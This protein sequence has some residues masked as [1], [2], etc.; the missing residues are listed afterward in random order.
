MPSNGY[1][2]ASYPCLAKQ[3]RNIFR[4]P[5][6]FFL[7]NAYATSNEF[8]ELTERL[9]SRFYLPDF[10]KSASHRWLELQTY[11]LEDLNPTLDYSSMVHSVEVRVPFLDHRIVEAA[12]SLDANTH[13]TADYGRKSPLKAMLDQH[14]I[15]PYIWARPK[16][17]FSLNSGVLSNLHEKKLAA[18]CEL[19]TEG[20][21]AI[22]ARVGEI[23][24][25][26]AYLGSAALAF[27]AWKRVWIDTGIVKA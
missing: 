17:G 27:A 26:F 15:H 2:T 6:N 21:L 18:L 23:W 19:R 1:E 13:I 12:L 5:E 9:E 4:S 14:G 25:D 10:P 20:Y 11:V 16:M 7:P 22:D 3:M 24:R 8:I